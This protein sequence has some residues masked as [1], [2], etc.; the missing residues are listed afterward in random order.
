MALLGEWLTEP[1][2]LLDVCHPYDGRSRAGDGLYDGVVVLGGAMDSW[3]DEGARWLPATRELVACGGGG[4]QTRR[5]D[6]CLGNQLAGSPWGAG[7]RA[8][9]RGGVG[10]TEWAGCPRRPLTRWLRHARGA[11]AVVHWNSDVAVALPDGATVLAS[12]PDGSVQAARLGEHVWGLQCHPEAGP[13]VVRGGWTTT[14]RPSRTRA[15]T[16]RRSPP[17]PSAGPRSWPTAGAASATASPRWPWPLDPP[18][19]P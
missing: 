6:I 13:D 3:D 1:G 8:T 9:R 2:C 5:W 12:A 19:L 17:T 14:P 7:W 15:W 11:G 4:R 10:V 18:I 16:G